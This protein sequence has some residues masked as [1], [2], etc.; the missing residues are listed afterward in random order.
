MNPPVFRS[1]KALFITL[2]ILAICSY[3]PWEVPSNE[4]HIPDQS[5]MVAVYLAV[6]V[7]PSI[8]EAVI[9]MVLVYR[10]WS[11]ASQLPP[12]EGEPA[13][14]PTPLT[15]ALPLLVPL[16]G[17]AW[18]FV[19]YGCLSRLVAVRSGQMLMPR[20][21]LVAFLSVSIALGLQLASADL[22]TA[23]LM[24]R[25][26][27]PESLRMMLSGITPVYNILQ[28]LVTFYLTRFNSFRPATVQTETSC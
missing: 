1:T 7:L 4:L 23:G 19:A 15:A 21:L 6:K 14:V 9:L 3:I 2:L 27:L 13:W 5:L 26:T 22:I 20:W 18:F 17:Y 16:F 10:T 24:P 25:P 28:L 8:A 12:G 11:N